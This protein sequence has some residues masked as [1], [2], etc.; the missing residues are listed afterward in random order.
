M[1]QDLNYKGYLIEITQDEDC[2]SPQEGDNDIFLVFDHRQFCVKVDGFDPTDIFEDAYSKGKFMYDGHHIFGLEAYIHSGVHLMLKDSR[3]A[4]NCPDRRWDVSFKGF[5]L[6]KRVKG[7]SWTRAKA[8]E[9]IDGF[10]KS[11]NSY[12]SGE[13]YGWNIESDDLN[14]SCWGYIGDPETSGCIEDAKAA[15]DSHIKS[16]ENAYATATV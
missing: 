9:K 8:R 1:E 14:E 7:W 11:W 10:L 6:V 2:D 12:N 3:E 4:L 15:I 13:V 5:V 16:K